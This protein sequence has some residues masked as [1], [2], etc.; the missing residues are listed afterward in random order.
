MKIGLAAD[1][2]GFEFKKRLTEHLARAGHE[3]VDFGPAALDPAD[4]YPDYGIP[5]A[6]A[7]SE[8]R[9]DRAVLVCNNGIGMGML[10]NRLPGVRGA[11]VYNEKTARETRRHHDSNVLCLGGQHFTEDELFRMVDAWLAEPFEGGRHARRM[12]KIKELE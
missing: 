10:A 7:V 1:H 2:G 12:A 11:V 8:G 9:A 5:A 4:D 6:R 3:V